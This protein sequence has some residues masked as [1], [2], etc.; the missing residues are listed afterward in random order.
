[1]T[2]GCPGDLLVRKILR[3]KH[4]KARPTIRKIS[5]CHLCSRPFYAAIGASRDG[6]GKARPLFAIKPRLMALDFVLANRDHRYLATEEEKVAYFNGNRGISIQALPVKIY[7]PPW[8]GLVV[9][10]HFADRFPIF[11]R[12][13]QA[14]SAP[15]VSFCYIDEGDISTPGFETYLKQ[16][17]GLFAA[18]GQFEVIFVS[19]RTKHTRE[20]AAAFNRLVGGAGRIENPSGEGR[21]NPF[22]AAESDER[23]AGRI[24]PRLIFY[25]MNPTYD[26][27]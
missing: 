11:L 18:L 24:R 2:R 26:F 12:Q 7:R 1:V 15:L 23:G 16:Y 27:L 6:C 13:D 8:T 3:R 22:P 21:V 19:T 20:A 9:A 17:A 5:I 25:P 4:G 10:R 14:A